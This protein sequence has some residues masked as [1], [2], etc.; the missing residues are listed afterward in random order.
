MAT[1]IYCTA[2]NAGGED[3]WEFAWSQYHISQSQDQRD[4][5]RGAL[6]CTKHIWLLKRYVIF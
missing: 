3:E 4:A 6:A 1:H 5:L 2:V